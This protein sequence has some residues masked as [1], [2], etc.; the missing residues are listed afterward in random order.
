MYFDSI[1]TVAAN[2]P[3]ITPTP[4]RVILTYGIVT[5]VSI[6]FV[7]DCAG[8]VGVR[9]KRGGHVVWPTNT[10]TWFIR[11][12]GEIKWQDNYDL[13]IRPH[14]LVLEGYNLDDSYEH[15]V[16][17]GFEIQPR[18]NILSEIWR[19]VTTPKAPPKEEL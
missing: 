12:D 3:I 6:F 10:D 2:T 11:N 1:L 16:I 4:K 13:T 19:R 17:F 18:E 5:L 9:V 14:E 7:P 8:Y 15:D